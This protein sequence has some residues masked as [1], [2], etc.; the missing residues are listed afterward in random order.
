METKLPSTVVVERNFKLDKA[1]VKV[2]LCTPGARA[3]QLTHNEASGHYISRRLAVQ[4]R[5]SVEY[6][7]TPQEVQLKLYQLFMEYATQLAGHTSFR[8]LDVYVPQYGNSKFSF[9]AKQESTVATK[10][11]MRF[12]RRLVAKVSDLV[13]LDINSMIIRENENL[14]CILEARAAMISRH[15]RVV[16]AMDV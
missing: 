5:I 10:Q 9:R 16:G 6:P 11:A 14:S 4:Y 8:L 7:S 3:D 2:E 15:L 12:I 13:S 1:I